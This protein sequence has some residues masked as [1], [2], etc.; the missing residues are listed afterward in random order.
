[1][2]IA[3][4]DCFAGVSGDMILGGLIDLGLDVKG[5]E[6]KLHSIGIDSF[7][8]KAELTERKRIR[9]MNFSVETG[10]SHH[11][12]TL[13]DILK[14]IDSPELSTAVKERAKRIFTRIAE[15]ESTIHQKPVD[16]I[17]FHEVGAIDS[18]VDIIGSVWGL[19]ELGI[20]ECFCSAISLGSGSV[21]CAH[22]TLSVPSPAT[23]ELV[24]GFPVIKKEIGVELATPTGV[25]II[26]SVAQFVGQMKPMIIEKT[27]YGCG[28][29]DLEEFPNI[30]RIIKGQP[31]ENREQDCVKIIETNLDDI[32]AEIVPYLLEK[33]TEKGAVDAFVTPVI[34][35]K[36]R[37]GYKITVLSDSEHLDECTNVLFSE[38]ATIGVRIYETYRQKL[39]REIETLNTPWGDVK[40]KAVILNGKKKIVPEYEECKKIAVKEDLPFI[41]VYTTIKQI[42]NSDDSV[43]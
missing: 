34:M 12:R 3:Y 20:T 22:G 21:D 33:L 1:M 43:R 29:R 28:D 9:A 30:V 17:H 31:V 42:G 36:G 23:L 8:L 15:A 35:K 37:P 24:K 38:S 26:T 7:T 19:E 13:Q 41:D 32:S 4:F 11:H 18:I 27:G 40:V 16:S 14:I 5:L 2:S 6:K 25:A 39:K 10:E